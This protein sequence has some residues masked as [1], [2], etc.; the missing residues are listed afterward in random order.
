MIFLGAIVLLGLV[1]IPGVGSGD[2]RGAKRWINLGFFNLQPSE[3][4]KLATII[5]LSARISMNPEKLKFF[6]K[7]LVPCFVI[8]GIVAA[9]LY[10]EPHYSAIGIIGLVIINLFV[11][12][13]IYSKKEN[14]YE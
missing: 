8:I 1:L 12:M 10:L 2:V 14:K 7:G 9:L 3:I 5:F 13:Y 11:L 4:A 6:W